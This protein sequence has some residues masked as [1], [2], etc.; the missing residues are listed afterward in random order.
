LLPHGARVYHRPHGAALPDVPRA[1]SDASRSPAGAPRAWTPLTGQR[2]LGLRL[3]NQPGPCPCPAR[4][5]LPPRDAQDGTRLAPAGACLGTLMSAP[6]MRPG[7]A[8]RA[9][10]PRCR[11]G[12]LN[13][14]RCRRTPRQRRGG[15]YVVRSCRGRY[16]TGPHSSNSSGLPAPHTRA[17]RASSLIRPARPARRRKTAC[18]PTAINSGTGMR[19]VKTHAEP[20][21]RDRPT[22]VSR[23]DPR[24][25]QI[26]M[27]G[28]AAD[29]RSCEEQ[30]C[31]A[32]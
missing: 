27:F 21:Y 8:A 13:R 26:R 24:L 12:L 28:A 18:E 20:P 17:K 7:G 22:G 3:T 30:K 31:D 5:R 6:T 25:A 16:P 29:A 19:S 9:A 10:S 2:Y 4:V 15:P 23:H 11:R 14:P 32:G 1:G